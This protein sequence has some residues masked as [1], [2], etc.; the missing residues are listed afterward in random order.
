[1]VQTTI[2][3]LLLLF[4]FLV[5]F[6]VRDKKLAFIYVLSFVIATHLALAVITQSFHLFIYPI[7]LAVHSAIA[8]VVLFRGRLK[9]AYL[10]LWT[11]RGI[12]RIDWILILLLAIV[13]VHLFHVHYNYSGKY[14]VVTTP[15]YQEAKNMRYSHP[16]FADE[17]Y[18]AVLAKDSLKSH[19]LP[20]SNP[21]IR[22]KPFFANFE[23]ASHSFLA[24]LFL[25]LN[26]DPLTD[27]TT[28]SIFFGTLICGLI[29]VFLSQ[30]G[31]SRF[32]AAIAGAS[33]LYLANGANLPGLWTLIP[34]TL[35]IISTLL[36]FLFIAAQKKKAAVL[37]AVL[38]LLFYPPLLVFYTTALILFFIF[39]K[40][41]TWKE[42]IMNMSGYLILSVLA[43]IILSLSLIF[44]RQSF[45]EIFSL[46][47]SKVFYSALT[48]DF[49]PQFTI[50]HVIPL[51]IL[52]LSFLSMPLITRKNFWLLGVF[53]LGLIYWFLYSLTTLRFFIE[54]PR[55]VY[56][57][58]IMAIITA[59]F[60][61][62]CFVGM[63]EETVFFRKRK[64]IFKYIQFGILG[65]FLIF[66]PYYTQSSEWQNF[67]E[68]NKKTN[69]FLV[70]AA[71]ANKYLNDDDLQLFKDIDNQKFLSFP[72]KGT[73]IGIATNNY[74]LSTKAGTITINPRLFYEFMDAD[75]DKK[76]E[77]AQT[78]SIH[79][80]YSPEFS[81][82]QFD[83]ISKS[84]EEL[85]LYKFTNLKNKKES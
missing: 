27:Y 79:F 45:H 22:S 37:A 57:T 28:L 11:K 12:L 72:W 38:I 70:P 75:C 49:N 59:G 42:K 36:G 1:M 39:L 41:L 81:C 4:P 32:P 34:L 8:L 24:E 47:S 30:N 18:A 69:Q 67:K 25:L 74:P 10:F 53:L 3:L 9:E 46:L 44:S 14:S 40:G 26:L 35:G 50:F 62:N 54:Y 23:F 16:Y 66:L 29:Y 48:G 65:C 17:W 5:I 51:P 55:V 71:P 78:K 6:H 7:I 2:G 15:N 64:N 82:P 83:F 73:V 21:L 19:S 77:I 43:G 56:F 58:S 76:S 63:L 61:L 60:S 33:V 31:V 84:S 68:Y 52:I 20:F 85:Y 80:V 13:F